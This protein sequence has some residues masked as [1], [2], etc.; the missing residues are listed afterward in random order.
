MR[1]LRH[2]GGPDRERS[3]QNKSARRKGVWDARRWSA[4]ARG[5]I[6]LVQGHQSIGSSRYRV[7]VG[8]RRGREFAHRRVPGAS[9]HRRVSPMC[10]VGGKK[11]SYRARCS[12]NCN[13]RHQLARGSPIFLLVPG[14]DFDMRG[15]ARGYTAG[16]FPARPRVQDCALLPGERESRI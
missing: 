7:A 6:Q 14:L 5:R 11:L 16:P 1:R 3:T 4:G 8:F 12:R 2:G 13:Q 15:L 9:L 10:L